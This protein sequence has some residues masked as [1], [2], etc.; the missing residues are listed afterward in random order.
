MLRQR[1]YSTQV[2]CSMRRLMQANAK[3][4]VVLFV[5]YVA[6]C[7]HPPYI[8]YPTF[9]RSGLHLTSPWPRRPRQQ[10]FTL[11]VMLHL[12]LCVLLFVTPY[13]VIFFSIHRTQQISFSIS[14]LLPMPTLRLFDPTASGMAR[15]VLVVDNGGLAG[16][17]TEKDMLNR[18]LSKGRNADEVSVSDVMTPNPDTVPS[19]MTVLEALQEVSGRSECS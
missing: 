17:F 5:V 19:T 4:Y 1:Q 16:I 8:R 18:V 12:S 11:T 2:R 9:L 6:H 13:S 3:T 15:Q 14:T 10:F 7:R